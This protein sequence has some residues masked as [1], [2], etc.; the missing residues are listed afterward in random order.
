MHEGLSGNGPEPEPTTSEELLALFDAL[1]D[2]NDNSPVASAVD[3]RL[4]RLSLELEESELGEI[5]R[6][7]E[8]QEEA[9]DE[10]M[11]GKEMLQLVHTQTLQGSGLTIEGGP[12]MLYPAIRDASALARTLDSPPADPASRDKLK[13]HMN[14]LLRDSLYGLRDVT[15][16]KNQ[17]RVAE[18]LRA[19]IP[20]EWLP[21]DDEGWQPEMLQSMEQILDHGESLARSL[22]ALGVVGSGV[23]NRIAGYKRQDDIVPWAIAYRYGL[24]PMEFPDGEAPEEWL[25]W[26]S[27]D[28]WQPLFRILRATA[29]GGTFAHD[30]KQQALVHMQ[31]LPHRFLSDAQQTDIERVRREL[32]EYPV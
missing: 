8:I 26:D 9:H 24:A 3:H 30:L 12:F 13:E 6:L 25:S 23:L 2:Y 15:I 10:R 16:L 17:Q 31:Y 14:D 29:P 32:R 20:E 5:E 22:G 1:H 21:L 4:M 18:I 19:T 11:L 27:Y 7:R 28:A